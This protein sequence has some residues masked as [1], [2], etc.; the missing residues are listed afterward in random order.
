MYTAAVYCI[1]PKCQYVRCLGTYKGQKN[2]VSV[3]QISW[4]ARKAYHSREKEHVVIKFSHETVTPP[5]AESQRLAGVWS[6]V[7]L[8]CFRSHLRVCPR[9]VIQCRAACYW[10]TGL[11]SQTSLVEQSCIGHTDPKAGKIINI[12]LLAEVLKKRDTPSNTGMLESFL[13]I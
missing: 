6:F 3:S 13:R 7:S 8:H 10:H 2:L 12:S 11:T 1:K 4:K 9:H 5:A